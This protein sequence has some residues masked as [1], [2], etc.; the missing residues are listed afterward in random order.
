MF[1]GL[2]IWEEK[3]PN[4]EKSSLEKSSSE[5][6][7]Y[8]QLQGTYPV[9]ALS[10][11]KVKETTYANAR[12]KICQ[13]I[14]TLYNQFDFL[15]ESG[16]LNEYEQEFFRKVSAEMEDYVATESLNA[17]SGYLMKYYGKRV[18]ILLDEYDT[19]M[20][21]AWVNGYWK[22]IVAFIRS[23]ACGK[24]NPKGAHSKVWVCFLRKEG[25]D[26][27]KAVNLYHSI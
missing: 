9:I 13:I 8:R 4:E 19:P 21:E 15:P 3:T 12:K 16:K 25:A 1:E 23:S 7:K 11:A 14:R 22:E 27:R 10:F 6:Y 24:E 26:R 2:S 17:L 20:Q 5:D 18:I